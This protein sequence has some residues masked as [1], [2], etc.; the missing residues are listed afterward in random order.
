MTDYTEGKILLID[1]PLDWTSFDIV[2]KIKYALK[3]TF[4]K[5]KV[6]HAGTLDP[7]A[8][9]L[10]IVCTGKFTK[11]ITEIQDQFKVYT[12]SF[13]LG[14]TTECFDTERPVNQNFDISN[15]SENDILQNVEKFR[16]LITQT[17]PAHSA[18]KIDGKAAYLSARK[19]KEVN[20]KSRE[21]M[22]YDFDIT[23]IELPEIYFRIKC[24]KGTYIRSI[25]NDFGLSLN[26]GAYL[27]SLRREA[28]G[29]Y[30][31]GDAWQI[32]DFIQHIQQ[33]SY[34]ED[35]SL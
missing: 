20:I 19:G 32:E 28:I 18:V 31:V 16:G 6:G 15:I 8:T 25:A 4:P 12:G 21:V 22:I 23:K 5:L 10:L 9:G 30:S 11:R 35:A 7:R 17:P 24:S 34:P 14:A 2:N 27:S 13:H 3:K 33:E 26:N 1:K 29:E